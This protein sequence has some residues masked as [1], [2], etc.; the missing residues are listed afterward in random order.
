MVLDEA[1][2][3]LDMGFLPCVEEMLDNASMVPTVKLAFRLSFNLLDCH[4]LHAVSVGFFPG[5]KLHGSVILF[6]RFLIVLGVCRA[7][8]R[9]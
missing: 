6:A 5:K 9:P 3:M 2:R 8:G 1:D 7:S 4:Y